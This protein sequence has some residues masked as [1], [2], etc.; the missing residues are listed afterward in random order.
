[1]NYLNLESLFVWLVSTK[2]IRTMY[3]TMPDTVE[4]KDT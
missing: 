1:M 4:T 2:S 3:I